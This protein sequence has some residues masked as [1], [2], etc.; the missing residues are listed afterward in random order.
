MPWVHLARAC[1]GASSKA[2]ATASRPRSA[3][4]AA[5]RGAPP[6]RLADQVLTGQ[7]QSGERADI[8]WIARQRGEKP[9]L[10]LGGQ[11]SAHLPAE[12]GL[13]AGDAFVDPEFGTGCGRGAAAGTLPAQHMQLARDPPGNLGLDWGEVFGPEFMP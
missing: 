13:G 6:P 12:C 3:A 1:P 11:I 7:G 4:A 5:G 8:A 2:S 9:L 10:G